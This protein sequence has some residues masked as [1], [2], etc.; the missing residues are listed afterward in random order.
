MRALLRGILHL[1]GT[2]SYASL[3]GRDG[4]RDWRIPRVRSLSFHIARR[5]AIASPGPK[6]LAT[7]LAEQNIRL[8][9]RQVRRYL[10]MMG[11]G[12][13]RTTNSLRHKQ[14]Q[15]EVARAVRVLGHL[16]KK[17][18]W[19]S[20]IDEGFLKRSEVGLRVAAEASTQGTSCLPSLKRLA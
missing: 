15:V 4:G 19:Q 12:W 7:A 8:S 3:N 5:R 2:A 6:Q 9:V 20:L 11:A 13:R 10:E 1:E 16:K 18:G 17:L 14:D